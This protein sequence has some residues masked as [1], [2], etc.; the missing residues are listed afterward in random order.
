MLPVTQEK[1]TLIATM[2]MH[3]DFLILDKFNG[4]ECKNF[5]SLVLLKAIPDL[6]DMPNIKKFYSSIFKNSS[7]S[8]LQ[9]REEDVVRP[10]INFHILKS[11][12]QN[13]FKG[14]GNVMTWDDVLDK[15]L[16][17]LKVFK[18]RLSDRSLSK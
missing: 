5:L 13:S 18:F 4:E 14:E 9:L 7:M 12:G 17:E 1:T 2:S 16:F 8:F 10:S 11:W 15:L 3:I 6:Q